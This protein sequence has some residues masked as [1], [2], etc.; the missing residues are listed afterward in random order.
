MK[1]KKLF[2]IFAAFSTASLYFSSC[3]NSVNDDIY[4][5]PMPVAPGVENVKYATLQGHISYEGAVPS[6][7]A[8]NTNSERTAM[9]DFGNTWVY[10]LQATATGQENPAPVV[11]NASATSY[12]Y[13][14]IP[15]TQAGISWT[16]TVRLKK[17]AADSDDSAIMIDSYQATLTNDNSVYVHDFMLKPNTTGS[18][19]LLLTMT[20]PSDIASITA[21]CTDTVWVTPVISLNDAGTTKIVTITTTSTPCGSYSVRFNFK[22]ANGILLYSNKQIINVLNNCVTGTWINNGNGAGNSDPISSGNYTVTTSMLAQFQLTTFYVGTTPI[23]ESAGTVAQGYTGTPAAPFSKIDEAITAIAAKNNSNVNYT[24]LVTG[25]VLGNHTIG[26][27]LNGKAAG[28]TIRGAQGLDTNNLPKDELRLRADDDTTIT[29]T[30]LSVRTSVPVII[31]NLRITKG[32]TE[33]DDAGGIYIDSGATV[34]LAGGALVTG[35]SGKMA[36]GVYNKG[37]LFMYGTARIGD[38]TEELAASSANGWANKSNNSDSEVAGGIYNDSSGTVYLGYDGFTDATPPQLH[39][40]TLSGGITRNYKCGIYTKGTIYFDSGNIAYN[41]S[42]NSGGGVY[43]KSDTA[44]L[45]M[46]GGSIA[47][48][49]AYSYGGGV[50]ITGAGEFDLQKGTLSSNTLGYY[51]QKGGAVYNGSGTFKL[52]KEA[53]ISSSSVKNNDIALYSGQKIQVDNTLDQTSFALDLTTT[54]RGTQVLTGSKVSD[55]HSKFSLYN[56]YGMGINSSGIIDLN[57]IVTE[58]YVNKNA[59]A[60]NSF[61]PGDAATSIH[62]TWNNS[63]YA[64]NDSADSSQSKPFRSIATALKFITFQKSEQDYTIHIIGTY[65]VTNNTEICIQNDNSN[66]YSPIKLVKNGTESNPVT[67]KSITIDGVANDTNPPIISG[68]NNYR[69]IFINTE[70][71]VIISNISIMNGKFTNSTYGT[72]ITIDN[73]SQYRVSDVTLS[74]GTIIKNNVGVYTGA[75]YNYG[76][77]TIAGA[78]ISDNSA[79]DTSGGFGGAIRNEGGIVNIYDNSTVIG[80]TGDDVTAPAEY[81]SSPTKKYSNYAGKSGGAIYNSSGTYNGSTYYGTINIGKDAEGNYSLPKIEY[82]YCAGNGGGIYNCSRCSINF[83]GGSVSYSAAATNGGGVYNLGTLSLEASNKYKTIKGNNAVKGGAV[84]EYGE[85]ASFSFTPNSSNYAYAE[86]PCNSSDPNTANTIYLDLKSGSNPCQIT[87]KGLLRYSCSSMKIDTNFSSFAGKPV[88]V[89]SNDYTPGIGDFGISVAWFGIKQPS[90]ITFPYY[91]SSEKLAATPAICQTKFKTATILSNASNA[92]P[93]DIVLKNGNIIQYETGLDIGDKKDDV[94]S[95]IC[96]K[97]GTRVLGVGISSYTYMKWST[98]DPANT[99]PQLAATVS[100]ETSS[101]TSNRN[102][103]G[104]TNYTYASGAYT[105]GQLSAMKWCDEYKN[106]NSNLEGTY[107]SGWYLPSIQEL[108]ELYNNMTTINT[109]YQNVLGKNYSFA[110]ACSYLGGTSVISTA[111]GVRY[112]PCWSSNTVAYDP[113]ITDVDERKLK[114]WCVFMGNVP[115][116]CTRIQALRWD[117]SEY[118]IQNQNSGDA[119]IILPIRQFN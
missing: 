84:Y 16:V 75:I 112:I 109:V 58:I 99:I 82:N 42:T 39:K 8:A 55:V 97:I 12:S 113:S 40:S 29:G 13:P 117:F 71:P 102:T 4:P 23:S 78:Q 19:T 114:I 98:T 34:K 56:V 10:V 119:G 53:S 26:S 64:F 115:N 61:E 76:T 9:T 28:I 105:T 88:I 49:H 51:G 106:H 22:D 57:V 37:K 41:Y 15:T 73:S 31:E 81:V 35:N 17:A 72:A 96:A 54:A 59:A 24:I 111:G 100:G 43:L 118:A 11:V 1:F 108:Y 63:T 90:G 65:A 38:T 47:N 93:G 66:S 30:T 74:S 69:C 3:F 14:N 62:T 107:Q 6:A 116:G 103:N 60:A 20:V 44:K 67:A 2:L 33:S 36:G 7:L 80:K 77:L 89:T 27:T 79:T 87:I 46:T 32:Y 83:Y 95:I 91:Y 5:I 110:N 85:Y 86:I 48:N 104:S 68:A 101:G 25:S 18:G 94:I 92:N 52:G 45:I 70:V 50:Y 21:E